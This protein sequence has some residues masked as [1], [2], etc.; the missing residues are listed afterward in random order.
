MSDLIVDRHPAGEVDQP[1]E[2]EVADVERT[3]GSIRA[4]SRC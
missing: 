1:V 4:M 2:V 3:A